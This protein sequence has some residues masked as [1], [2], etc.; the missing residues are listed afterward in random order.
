MSCTRALAVLALLVAVDAGAATFALEARDASGAP[1]PDVV[2]ALD[3]LDAAPARAARRATIDQLA[4]Q[5]VP[6]VSVVQTGTVVDFPNSDR[7]RHQVYS[8]SEPKRFNLKLYAGTEAPPITFDAPGLVVLGCN[9]H[10]AMIAFVVVVD[11]PHF[12]KT[13]TNG[14]GTLDVPPGRYRLRVWH[15][16]LAAGIAPREVAVAPAG[17]TQQLT[18]ATTASPA[19]L[20]TWP[21]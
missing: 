19:T 9:I 6:K 15:P 5:F 8:F 7:I 4:K 18:L 14:R 12:A 1:L 3:P 20:A 21:D 10:D 16:D 17:A 13:A 2:V 11:T